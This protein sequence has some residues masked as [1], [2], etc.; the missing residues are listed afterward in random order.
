MAELFLS[1]LEEFFEN[2]E[3]TTLKEALSNEND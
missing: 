3:T 1:N 2:E